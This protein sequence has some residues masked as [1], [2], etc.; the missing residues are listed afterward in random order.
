MKKYIKAILDKKDRLDGRTFDEFRKPITISNEVSNKAEGSAR[1]KIGDTEVIAG[2]KV[3]V[4]T[5]YPDSQNRGNLITNVELLPVA[6]SKFL[7]GPPGPQAVELSRIV[8]RGI[9]ESGMLDFEKLCIREGEL[10]YNII[11][12][13]Y[14]INDAGNLIDASAFAAVAALKNAVLPKLVDDKVQFGEFTKTKVPLKI[15]P[16]TCTVYKIGE[17]LVVDLN[18]DEEEAIDARLSIAVSESGNVH[19]MQKGGIV[20]FSIDEV[21]K[22]IGMAKK[23]VEKLRKQLK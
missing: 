16:I 6:S 18:K 15:I 1:V 8:D 9:R 21:D 17:H 13:I 22:A 4:G 10:V 5:P 7:P 12:D 20:G 11:V 3:D 23:C 19:A 14:P 2:I